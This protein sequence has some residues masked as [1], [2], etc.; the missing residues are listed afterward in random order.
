MFYRVKVAGVISPT[1]AD[2]DVIEHVIDLGL[3]CRVEEVEKDVPEAV[4]VTRKLSEYI[5]LVTVI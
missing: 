2:S 5:G 3:I 1:S 4:A